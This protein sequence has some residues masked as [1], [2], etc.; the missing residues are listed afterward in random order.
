MLICHCRVVNDRAVRD[1]IAAGARAPEDV[2]NHCGAGSRCGG[3]LPA[4]LELLAEQLPATATERLQPS[5]A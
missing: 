2:A 1:A 5:T 3:C 4:L